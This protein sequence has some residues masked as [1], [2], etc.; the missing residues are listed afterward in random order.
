MLIRFYVSQSA[1]K[2]ANSQHPQQIFFEQ[3]NLTVLSDIWQ[4]DKVAYRVNTKNQSVLSY[5]V[6]VFYYPWFGNPEDDSVYLHWK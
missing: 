5:N 3:K 2:P 1:S 4:R 6:H